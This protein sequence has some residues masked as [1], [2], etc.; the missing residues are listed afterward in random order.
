MRR[1]VPPSLVLALVL[2]GCASAPSPAPAPAPAAP[3][4]AAPAAAT[5][6]LPDNLHWVRN[7]AEHR[8][9]YVGIY[10]A[11]GDRLEQLVAGRDPWTW[12]VVLDLDET[13]LDNSLYQKERAA[14][15]L[16]FTKPSW[17]AWVRRREAVALPGA[18]E[19]L[20]RV[21]SLG[22]R[23]AVV[24]NRDQVVCTESEDNL[25]AQRIPY[26]LVLCQPDGAPADKQPRFDAI[27]QGRASR[28]LPPLEIVEWL[29]DDIRDFPGGSQA[30]RDAP[31]AAL[32]EVGD[33]WFVFPDPMYGSWL[34][35]PRR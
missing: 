23:I 26:D 27:V 22:G 28:Y 25:R 15:G 30:L 7:S 8:A 18:V 5:V 13:L 2:A 16:G 1:H 19:F 4:P 35:T 24:T 34:A 3:L 17:Q 29:G 31:D 32:T 10:R 21:R 9:V 20:E 6:P 33:H 12:A 11:A 14:Q